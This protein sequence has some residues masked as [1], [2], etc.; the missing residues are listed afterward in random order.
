MKNIFRVI[1]VIIGTLIG[2]GFA[3]GREIY[4]FFG[5]YGE[6]GKIGIILSGI[7]TAII[8]YRV[9]ELTKMYEI[10]TYNKLLERI[11]WK[12]QK[13]NKFINIIV[14]AFLLISFYIMIAG[15]SAYIEQTYK[16]PI[17]IS[18]SMFVFICY[19][20]F[21]RSI[22]GVIK[23]NEVLVPFLILLVIYLGI[24]NLPYMLSKNGNILIEY[25]NRGW[26]FNSILYASYNSILLI[27]VLTSLRNYID[28]K[29]SIIKISIISSIIVIILAFLIYGLLLRGQFFIQELEMPLIEI[30]MQF[31]KIFKYIYG[32]VIIASIFT[33]AISTGYSFLQDISKSKKSYNIILLIMCVTGI[34]ISNIGFSK[35]VELLYPMFGILGLIQ[36]FM[37]LKKRRY[38]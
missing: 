20:I 1:F 22:Q 10:N 30:T 27:P 31:G 16:I 2:A 11:N 32:F 3:S 9:L 4:L 17:Y 26:L 13:L 21:K 6:H 25:N 8:I 14:N 37:L 24:K 28:S 19:I 33:S 36:I 35:L 5:R 12:H 34:L 29:K 23:A 38:G 15:F 7:L 18:S